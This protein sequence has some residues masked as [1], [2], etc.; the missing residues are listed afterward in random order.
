MNLRK[1]VLQILSTKWTT[2]DELAEVLSSEFPSEIMF[3]R[4]YM[5]NKKSLS[6]ALGPTLYGLKNAGLV[7]D[8]GTEWPATK[9]WKRVQP[10]EQISVDK[11]AEALIMLHWTKDKEQAIRMLAART[12][13]EHPAE[14]KELIEKVTRIREESKRI[15]RKVLGL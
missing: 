13:R 11:A 15:G 7:E 8:D 9:H 10:K 3:E 14:F 1:Y 6:Q 12:I 4:D 2:T 5:G